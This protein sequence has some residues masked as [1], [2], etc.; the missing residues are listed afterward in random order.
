VTRLIAALALAFTA[1]ATF[2]ADE[3]KE[4]NFGIIS[5][6]SSANLKDAWEPFRA[7]LEK[8]FGMPVKPFFA[9]DYAGVI[10]AMRFK[11]IELAW[12]GNKS[13]VD[14]VDRAG[15]EVF[16][17]VVDAD[18]QAG[19]HSW[20]IVRND[21]PYQNL[22]ELFAKGKE[23]NFGMGDPQST[24]GTLVPGYYIFAKRGVKPEEAFKRVTSAKHE[25]NALSVVAGQLDA[26]TFNSEA[27]FR[28]QKTN[29]E[30]AGMIRK[31][32]ESPMIASDPLCI[33]K[34]LPAEF[35][36][37]A[38]EIF[39]GYGKTD[40]EK[41]TIAVLKWSGF[42]PSTDAQLLPTRQLILAKKKAELE[43]DATMS[44]DDKKAKIAE[45]DKQL[46]ELQKQLDA[47]PKT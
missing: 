42:R 5:T 3:I 1:S 28:L 7:D 35:K 47:Q 13:A 22:D 25:A 33:R 29:A 21:S 41:A 19:Y 43:N 32:W 34:E 37:K 6:E 38:K 18:G 44:A 39:V 20:V 46:A 45:L 4:I 2:A 15:A 17:Q 30:K 14:A 24:S 8:K 40:A 27:F 23:L 11:K 36:A 12:F 26:S 31:I 9:S 10:E 16:A